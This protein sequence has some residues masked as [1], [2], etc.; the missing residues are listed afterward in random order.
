M[1]IPMSAVPCAVRYVCVAA[2]PP[3]TSCRSWTGMDALT[4][5]DDS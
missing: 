1:P 2:V 4:D 5:S 3:S